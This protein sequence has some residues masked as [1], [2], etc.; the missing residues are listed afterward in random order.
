[1]ATVVA[2][3]GEVV[4]M[5]GETADKLLGLPG[6]AALLY[7]ALCRCGGDFNQAERRLRW[8]KGRLEAA[9]EALQTAGLIGATAEVET[10]PVLQDNA[11]PEY[12]TRDV[13]SA[14][15]GDAAFAGL[16]REVERRLGS[17][18]TPADLKQLYTI[19]DYLALPPE[20]ILMLTIWCVEEMES[21]YGIGRRPRMSQVKKAAYRWRDMGIDTL[22]AAEEF[23]QRQKGLRTRER[24]LL[25]RIGVRG[26]APLDK[27]RDYLS[28]WIDWGFPDEA[29]IMA[30]EKTLLKKQTMSWPYMNSILKSWHAKGLH[31]PGEIEAGDKSPEAKGPRTAPPALRESQRRRRIAEDLARLKHTTGRSGEDG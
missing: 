25:P 30:Y 31:T 9:Y 12:N 1:M 8:A 7:I 11:P 26:R 23:L 4:S 27:E 24:E 13:V 28:T 3:A 16:Q 18:L 17:I 15:E 20:V 21:K 6:D 19:Y 2:L 5:T 22:G 10:A 29:I 14:L